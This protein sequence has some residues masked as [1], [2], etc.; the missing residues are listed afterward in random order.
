MLTFEGQLAR[1]AAAIESSGLSG[2]TPAVS[3]LKANRPDAP[4]QR[5]ASVTATFI[6]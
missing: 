4:P 1:L 6:R 5:V 3:W 2:L